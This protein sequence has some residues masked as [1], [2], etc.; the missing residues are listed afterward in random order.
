[1]PF[2]IDCEGDSVQELSCIYSSSLGE[3][4]DVY[5]AFAKSDRLIDSYARRHVHGLSVQ[6]LNHHGFSSEKELVDDF[7]IWLNG[8]PK[9]IMYANNPGKE[10]KLL[11]FRKIVDLK[12]PPWIKRVN[13]RAYIRS[14]QAKR[15]GR[16]INGVSC[17]TAHSEFIGWR[18]NESTPTLTDFAKIAHGH[19]C[20]LYDCLYLFLYHN[21]IK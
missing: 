8:K 7:N 3:V 21:K 13:E 1:M 11:R 9:D 10:R 12:V 4:I 6:F 19:H 20:S 5:H 16:L 14:V 18:C 15:Q 17:R 2:F